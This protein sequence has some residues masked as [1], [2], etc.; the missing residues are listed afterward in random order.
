MRRRRSPEVI[1]GA[2][3]ANGTILTGEGFTV[4]RTSAG[5]YTITFPEDFR[6]VSVTASANNTVGWADMSGA[7]PNYITIA[8]FSTNVVAT[9][10][11]FSFVAVGAQK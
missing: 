2:V 8:M 11:P 3:A 9:D 7:G 4:Q 1:A 6:I 10:M 5:F